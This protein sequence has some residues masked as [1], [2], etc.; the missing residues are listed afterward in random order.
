[1][2]KIL[3]V[4]TG[5]TCRSCMAEGLLRSALKGDEQLAENYSA[6]SCGIYA[7]NDEPASEY[8]IQILEERWNIDI[9]S[10]RSKRISE[11]SVSAAELIVT[12]TKNQSDL[13]KEL[14]PQFEYKVYVLREYVSEVCNHYG[15]QDNEMFFD[16]PDPYGMDIDAYKICAGSIKEAIDKMVIKLKIKIEDA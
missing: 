3:F 9:T 13:I 2:K 7:H 6:D 1:M 8:A 15:N 14:Y 4:C 16:I 10:H 5:N 11:N 12:M